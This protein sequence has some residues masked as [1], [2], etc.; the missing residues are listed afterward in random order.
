MVRVLFA[1]SLVLVAAAGCGDV[2]LSNATVTIER[3]GTG[4]GEFEASFGTVDC[5]GTACTVALPVGATTTIKPA[6]ATGSMFEGWAAGACDAFPTGCQLTVDDDVSLSAAFK[7]GRAT[8]T[9]EKTGA[10]VARITSSPP[11]IDCGVTCTGEFDYGTMVTLTAELTAGS[12]F[13]AWSGPCTG[14]GDCTV[15]ATNVKATAG[16]GCD[17]GTQTF[18]YTGTVQTLA[19]PACVTNVTIEAFGAQGG[20]TG[21]LGAQIKGT[22]A[23]PGQT[24]LSIVVGGVGGAPAVSHAG[25]GGGGSFVYV[26]PTSSN[27]L[28]VAG[29]GGGRTFNASCTSGAGSATTLPTSSSGGAGN[30]A[31]GTGTNGGVGGGGCSASCGIPGSGGG[32]A[33]WSTNGAN[34]TVTPTP[35]GG[36]IAPRNGAAGGIAGNV[37]APGGFGGGGGSQGDAGAAGGGG[38]YAGGG[39]GNGWNGSSWGCGGGGASFNSGD[40]ATQVN[41]AGVRSGDGQVIITW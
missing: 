26:Q 31:G 14:T 10:G 37:G 15:M 38:G 33:G 36:G 28:L 3:T 12:T 41:T 18:N 21:G 9:V 2:V 32:G 23:I 13:Q 17:A 11:G 1:R 7:L 20:F 8:V 5:S 6:P 34:G 22:V 4:S 40:A 25:G 24:T 39:G 19:L 29:G 35:A 16:L 27:P 30:A